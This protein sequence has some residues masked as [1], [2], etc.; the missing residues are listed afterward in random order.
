MLHARWR[1]WLVSPV[2]AGRRVAVTHVFR[3]GSGVVCDVK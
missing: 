2:S 3:E 1:E